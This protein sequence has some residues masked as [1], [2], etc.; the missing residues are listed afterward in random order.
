MNEY[1]AVLKKYAVFDGRAGRRE[2]WL[3]F[4]VNLVVAAILGRLS[5]GLQNLYT[6]AVLL[7]NIGVGIRRLHDT[8]RSGWWMLLGFVPVVGWIVIIVF[9]IQKGTAG[10]NKYGPVPARIK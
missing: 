10:S 6:L 7:P 9:A 1:L 8:D 4:L 5:S 3:F 2:F